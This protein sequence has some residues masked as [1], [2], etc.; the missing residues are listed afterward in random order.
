[1]AYF[2]Q[3][4]NLLLPRIDD[5]DLSVHEWSDDS[6]LA[7]G[8]PLEL[9]SEFIKTDVFEIPE[10]GE[11]DKVINVVSVPVGIT[12][13]DHWGSIPV[14]QLLN[15]FSVTGGD[16]AGTAVSV[17]RKRISSILRAGH[18]TQWRRE[19]RFC[20]VCGA[21]NADAAAANNG[22]THRLCPECG[23]LEFPRIC[24][25]IIVAITDNDNRILLARNKRFRAGLY[26]H[27]SGFNEA[28]ESLEETVVREVRE[29][30]NVE[31]SDVKYINSQPW[32]FPNSLMIGFKARYVSGT[33]R[34]D[35]EEIEDAKWFAKDNLPELPGEGSLSRILINNWLANVL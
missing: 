35:G 12:L 16:L 26:S 28:G 23:Q 3:G 18:V 7:R 22:F 9:A 11:P 17:C 21:K 24:P 13:P 6:E 5:K 4:D 33:I 15:L 27:I 32:P 10:I 1:M 30:I 25:A 29:E 2:F 20:G 8:I 14:R 19:S 34:P 31:V